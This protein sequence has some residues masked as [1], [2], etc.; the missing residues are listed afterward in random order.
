MV[1]LVI[2]PH[3]FDRVAKRLDD[4]KVI[5]ASLREI[6]SKGAELL[7]QDVQKHRPGD[8]AFTAI[9]PFDKRVQDDRASVSVGSLKSF[10]VARA[11]NYGERYHYRRGPYAGKPTKGWFTGA[12]SRR[13]A[14][15][16]TLLRK[17]AATL[18]QRLGD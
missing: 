4:P 18:E 2:R 15:I 13:K 7:E 12:L 5:A 10:D 17:A 11:L 6:F 1:R 8:G 16:A 3:N 9:G 14:A